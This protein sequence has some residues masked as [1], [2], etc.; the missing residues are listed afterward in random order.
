MKKCIPFM[1][2][3]GLL[4]ASHCQLFAASSCM[5]HTSWWVESYGGGL[6]E[7]DH[8]WVG[9]ANE[10]FRRLV[11]AAVVRPN[12]VPGLVIVRSLTD[13]WCIGLPDGG[14]VLS[15]GG[16]EICYNGVD[17]KTGDA[18]LAFVLAHELSHLA[19]DDFR[20]MEAAEY[21]RRFG[22]G[23]RDEQRKILEIMC[24][25]H[26][27]GDIRHFREA[28]KSVRE[29]EAWADSE[30][31]VLVSRAGYDPRLV[32]DESGLNFFKK[33]VSRITG[34]IAFS[35]ETH[36]D[37]E[38]R[39]EMVLARVRAVAADVDLFHLGVRL[40]QLGR[41]DDALNL[42]EAFNRK[43]PSR[44]VLNNMG[45]IHY[46][47]A[48]K[49]L[50]FC[51]PR[52]AF[53]YDL[54]VVLDP[55]TRA[56]R[57]TL[58]GLEECPCMED[59]RKE[60]QQAEDLFR[61]ARHMDA[62]YIPARINLAAVLILREDHSEAVAVLDEVLGVREGHP[63]ALNNRAIALMAMGPSINVDMFEQAKGIL[64]EL[65]LDEPGY[66][67]ALYNLGRLQAD[68][69]R[70]GAAER[71][72]RKYLKHETGDVYAGLVEEAL[73]IERKPLEREAKAGEHDFPSPPP[74]ALGDCYRNDETRKRL[75]KLDKRLLELACSTVEIYPR[76]PCST[77]EIYSGKGLR[78][79]AADFSVELVDHA[80]DESVDLAAFKEAHGDPV[81][82]FHSPWGA[83]TLVYDGFAV[84]ILDGKVLRVA[85]F[86]TM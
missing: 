31:V 59:Y 47:R 11:L 17:E 54:A 23:D 25:N 45:L 6:T 74:V 15:R 82:V 62:E 41:Y 85:H 46:Q 7:A 76:F 53:R 52:K 71:T 38:D 21:V 20:H 70:K 34:Q 64:E 48:L 56:E 79:L 14:I 1:V 81:R 77:L 10:V 13:P 2:A 28:V 55:G 66:A 49:H 72:W 44:E 75:G 27:G 22:P 9:R 60:L 78:V 84:D 26:T 18:R 40:Y 16:L 61:R 39:A 24:P 42:L 58:K 12:R 19:L 80:V 8:P 63:D 4:F 51:D 50:A 69:G 43:F 68:R 35:D 33:W 65:I 83:E 29:K 36:P 32:A 86:V 3:M 73:E 30:A 57:G 37:P 67:R 5:N